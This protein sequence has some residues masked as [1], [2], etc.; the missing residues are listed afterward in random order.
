MSIKK[1]IWRE[2]WERWDARDT[3]AKVKN[4]KR[5]DKEKGTGTMQQKH[6]TRTGRS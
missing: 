5:G 4:E 6:Q 1:R 3:C 2:R